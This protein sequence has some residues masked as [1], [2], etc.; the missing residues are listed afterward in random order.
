MQKRPEIGGTTQDFDEDERFG[1]MIS[2]RPNRRASSENAPGP[3]QTI[4]IAIAAVRITA[5]LVTNRFGAGSGNHGN[6][7]ATLISPPTKTARGVIYP[8]KAKA[9]LATVSRPTAHIAR[10]GLRESDR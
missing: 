10:L 1:M 9:P 6:K 2:R 5:S 4:A 3:R 8:I 7:L